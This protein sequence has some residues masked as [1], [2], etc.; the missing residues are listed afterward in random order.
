MS[1]DNLTW[2]C[3]RRLCW[4]V[5]TIV[6]AQ[7]TFCTFAATRVTQSH[8]SKQA[9]ATTPF[10][11]PTTVDRITPSA[12]RRRPERCSTNIGNNVC[13]PCPRVGSN[14][15]M[16]ATKVFDHRG[17]PLSVYGMASGALNTNAEKLSHHNKHILLYIRVCRK[18]IPA[19]RPISFDVPLGL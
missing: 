7:G 19:G 8:A 18:R 9:L 11:E 5:K 13:V 17:I 14:S 1:K 10:M 15:I 6:A 4:M 3:L 2:G 16:P 12:C